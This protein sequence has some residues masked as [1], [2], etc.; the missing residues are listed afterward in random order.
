VSSLQTIGLPLRLANASDATVCYIGQMFCPIN[1]SVHYPF[2]VKGLPLGPVLAGALLLA[3]ITA[4]VCWLGRAHPYLPVGW[5]WYLGTL[6]PVIGLVQVGRQARADRYTYIP[7]IGLFVL[8]VWGVRE[9]LPNRR[10]RVALA[11]GVLLA[12]LFLTR[13]Q[14][15]HWESTRE[16]WAHAVATTKDNSYARYCYG[17]ILFEL[18][19]LESATPQ[20]QEAI[21]ISPRF[22]DA[23]FLLGHIQEEL[24]CLD[25][26][27]TCYRKAIELQPTNNSFQYKLAVLLK[28]RQAERAGQNPL[29][30]ALNNPTRAP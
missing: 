24:G 16:I 5:F 28:R 15:P 29:P 14:V 30:P 25:D 21:Q 11:A 6:V 18:K 19:D 12:C 13:A 8:L 22:A 9:L 1:L 2:P 20:V 17:K 7:L 4:A 26:A 27:E 10:V 23:H 3:G